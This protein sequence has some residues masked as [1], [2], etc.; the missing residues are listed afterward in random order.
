MKLTFRQ[1]ANLVLVGVVSIVAMAWA[2]VGLAGV[3]FDDPKTM[4]VQLAQSGGALSGAEV[5]YLGVPIG[6]VSATRLT[7]DAVELKLTIRPKGAMAET[8]RADVRQ[9]SSLGE[10][11][12]DLGPA[13]PH[14]AKTADPDGALVPADRTSTPRPLYELLGQADKVLGKIEPADLGKVA[15][16]LSGMVGHEQDLKVLLSSWA[17]VGEVMARRRAELGGLLADSAKLTAALDAARAD[18]AGAISGYARVGEVLDRHTAD[19][20]RILTEGARLGTEGSDLLAGSAHDIE[21]TLAGLDTTFHNLAIRPTKMQETIYWMPRFAERIGWTLE[22]DTMNIGLGGA[23]P[24]MPGYQ[25]RFGVPVYGEGLRLDKIYVPS[26]AQRID[27]DFGRFQPQG[28]RTIALVSP[29]DARYASQSTTHLLEIIDKK[30]AEID[31]QQ[32]SRR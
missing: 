7:D 32:A 21:G 12:V 19:L 23:F 13:D 3:K 9:K 10:P 30:Q 5:T 16:G 11:Y 22:G 4:R 14:A 26:L 6:K 18:M 28:G 15:D 1:I 8:L 2:A 27:V 20:E 17:D 31:R 24:L 25:P 29:E